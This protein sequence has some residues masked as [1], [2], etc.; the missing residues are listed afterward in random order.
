MKKE[1]TEFTNYL[2]TDTNTYFTKQ[3]L[4]NTLPTIFDYLFENGI[5]AHT[6][7]LSNVKCK[8]CE[9]DH[10]EAIVEL[11]NRY[12]TKC[13]YSEY[14]S[15]TELKID[16]INTYNFSTNSFLK[17]L[18]REL[19]LTDSFKEESSI[20]FNLGMLNE[21]N[22]FFIK[23]NS[24]VKISEIANTLNTSNNLII[25][26]GENKKTGFKT[27]NLVP[28]T[29]L[30]TYKNNKIVASLEKNYIKTQQIIPEKDSTVLDEQ[31]AISKNKLFIIKVGLEFQKSYSIRPQSYYI[32]R[33]LFDIRDNGKPLK[34]SELSQELSIAPVKVI[35]TRIGEVNK[36]CRENNLKEIVI[37]H[38]NRTWILNPQLDCF[39]NSPEHSPKKLGE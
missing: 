25:W 20:L 16:E 39:S 26:L 37:K 28:L 1:I 34:A 38:L 33:Y 18:C 4:Q 3:E 19:K 21:N 13:E 2:S 15:L 29:K 10:L 35:Q 24:I 22:L 30:L 14:A 31:I 9:Y 23:S 17:L 32:I 36:I 11:N 12:F 7:P 27:Y 5:L 8:D 6:N